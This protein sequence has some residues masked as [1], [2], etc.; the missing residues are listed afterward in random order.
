LFTL[1]PVSFFSEFS[2]PPFSP[3]DL[4]GHDLRDVPFLLD[5]FFCF[6]RRPRLTGLRLML[7]LH[8]RG[9]H[10]D[11][12]ILYFSLSRF[13][14]T[15]I[16]FRCLDG[17]PFVLDGVQPPSGS[18]LTSPPGAATLLFHTISCIAWVD[19]FHGCTCCILLPFFVSCVL[20]FST[21]F[22]HESRGGAQFL[23][24]FLALG[25]SETR[26]CDPLTPSGFTTPTP[27]FP[28]DQ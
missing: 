8:F 17:Q 18:A 23:L 13:C 6:P 28:D 25:I 1:S 14:S 10:R 12:C 15:S 3:A 27:D 5:T 22:D 16:H 20:P 11:C 2:T 4:F 19:T 26:V 21:P 7:Y 24:V 9:H